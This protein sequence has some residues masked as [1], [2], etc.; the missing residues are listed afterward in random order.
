M[1]SHRARTA[2]AP[3]RPRFDIYFYFYFLLIWRLHSNQRPPAPTQVV[4][5]DRATGRPRGF[6]FVTYRD[7]AV[8][9]RVVREVHV[10]DERQVSGGG[11]GSRRQH[12]NCTA[13]AAISNIT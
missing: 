10:V 12:L 2:A 5:R 7:P 3:V 13:A 1:V 6:G 8:V 9:D 4:M 11:A